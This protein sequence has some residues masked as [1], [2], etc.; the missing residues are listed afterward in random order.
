MIKV[1]LIAF[2]LSALCMITVETRGGDIVGKRLPSVK[3]TALSGQEIQ[4]PED[5][6]GV[7][8]LLLVA[9]RRG[10][11]SDV[12]KWMAFV[13]EREPKLAFFEVPA[14]AGIIWRPMSGW[15]DNGMRGGVAKEK[16]SR[17]V[18]LYAD[19]GTLRDFLGDYGGYTTHAVLVD[20]E[21]KVAW[22]HAGGFSEKAA[23]SLQEAI[24]KLTTKAQTP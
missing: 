2:A 9:Y 20:R 19:A 15:I 13:Q 6:A 16:W 17:V 5:L 3:G 4:F 14:I 21:G 8:T 10:T 22:F 23:A 7:P 11:Q 1:T 24:K 18:T 12:D